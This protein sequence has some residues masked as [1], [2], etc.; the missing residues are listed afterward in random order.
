MVHFFTF[1]GNYHRCE[2]P[3]N[4]R[5]FIRVMVFYLFCWRNMR[6]FFTA[7]F[8]TLYIYM[9]VNLIYIGEQLGDIFLKLP[10]HIYI[11]IDTSINCFI[12]VFYFRGAVCFLVI[13]VIYLYI[14]PT[15]FNFPVILF[16]I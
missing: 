3:G 13:F 10:W 5:D 14:S 4:Y 9:V 11:H 15:N 8:Y 16:I 1:L 2:L 6:I 7:V 12:T